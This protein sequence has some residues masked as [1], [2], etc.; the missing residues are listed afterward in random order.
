MDAK[1][2]AMAA[3]ALL[4]LAGPARAVTGGREDPGLAR[5]AVMILNDRGGFCSASVIAP[6]VVLTAAHC[7]TGTAGHR[8]HWRA[9]NGEPVLVVPA[10]IAVHPGYAADAVKARKKSVDLALVRLADPLP[11][12]FEP[13]ALSASPAPRPG[14][15]AIVGGWGVT[16]DGGADTG[17]RFR[18]VSVGIVEPYGQSSLLLWLSSGKGAGV[19]ACA[20]DSGG[21]VFASDGGVIAVTAFAEGASGRGCG[22]LTQAVLVGPQRGWIEKTLQRWGRALD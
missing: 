7:V 6:D 2:V 16:S 8:V 19:G 14:E 17:G 13:V 9:A 1:S 3:M 15:S 12:S 18:S 10:D 5:H 21:P 11:A 4:V 20:G 22:A